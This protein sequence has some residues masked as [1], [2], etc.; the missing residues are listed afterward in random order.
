MSWTAEIFPAQVCD[1]VPVVPCLN[2]LLCLGCSH[3]NPSVLPRWERVILGGH[4][5]WL[6]LIMSSHYFYSWLL[7]S[8][9]GTQ[10]A[11]VAACLGMPSLWQR[12]G[13]GITPGSRLTNS[14]AKELPSNIPLQVPFSK[15]QPNSVL[16]FSWSDFLPVFYHSWQLFVLTIHFLT[17]RACFNELLLFLEM[18]PYP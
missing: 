5:F 12:W 7:N 10:R 6:M 13:W 9:G 1:S 2:Q 16:L 8:D 18:W 14:G 3:I 11:A 17:Q 15:P 4:S